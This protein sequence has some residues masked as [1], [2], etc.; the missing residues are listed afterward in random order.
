MHITEK[1]TEGIVAVAEDE[2]RQREL[3]LFN[4]DVNTFAH[5]IATLIRVCAHTPEQAEQCALLVH[6][7]GKCTVKTGAYGYLKPKCVQLLQA[8]LRAQVK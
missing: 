1:E 5:V 3:V 2:T 6:Y 7:Q 4:D 8:G